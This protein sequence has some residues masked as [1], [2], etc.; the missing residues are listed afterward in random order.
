M[1]YKY[2]YKYTEEKSLWPQSPNEKLDMFTKVNTVLYVCSFCTL[3]YILKTEFI[4]VMI[5]YS[6]AIYIVTL[7]LLTHIYII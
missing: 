5:M 1:L 3:I 2:L 4:Y 6:L 7:L